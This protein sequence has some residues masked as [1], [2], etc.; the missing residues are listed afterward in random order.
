MVDIESKEV[1][2]DSHPPKTQKV[3]GKFKVPCPDLRGFEVKNGGR[4]NPVEKS[5]TQL[6]VEISVLAFIGNPHFFFIFKDIVALT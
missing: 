6:L 4:S 1:S 5:H 2:T 3:L